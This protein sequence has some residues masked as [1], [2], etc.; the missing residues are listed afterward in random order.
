MNRSLIINILRLKAKD[1]QVCERKN[2]LLRVAD[3][4]EANNTSSP[5]YIKNVP[6]HVRELLARFGL[7]LE[8]FESKDSCGY[9][10]DYDLNDFDRCFICNSGKAAKYL[11]ISW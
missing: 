1:E 11:K 2:D 9:E 6:R 8:R 3:S 7:K 10:H 5:L 4:I